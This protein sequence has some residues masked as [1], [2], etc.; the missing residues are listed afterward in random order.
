MDTMEEPTIF[1]DSGKQ[2]GCVYSKLN[3]FSEGS[4]VL[5][6]ASCTDI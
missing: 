4:L 5:G 1:A 3:N 6:F 2:N